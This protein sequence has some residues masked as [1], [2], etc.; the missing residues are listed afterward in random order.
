D[1]LGEVQTLAQ[2]LAAHPLQAMQATKGIFHRVTE[3]PFSEGLK[4]GQQLNAHM[5]AFRQAESTE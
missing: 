4:I 5:R 3:L 1:L 2:Q